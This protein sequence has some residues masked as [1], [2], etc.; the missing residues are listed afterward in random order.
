MLLIRINNKPSTI[1]KSKNTHDWAHNICYTNSRKKQAL[2]DA[3]CILNSVNLGSTKELILHL[4]H[5]ASNIFC[6][7]FISQKCLTFLRPGQIPHV[8]RWRSAR[9]ASEVD[10]MFQRRHRNHLRRSIQLLQ[11]GLKFFLF[12]LNFLG[13]RFSRPKMLWQKYKFTAK[14]LK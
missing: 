10:P 14:K 9:R 2:K 3:T 7:N 8:R 11:H 1:K 5:L 6:V 12:I 4:S 13:D